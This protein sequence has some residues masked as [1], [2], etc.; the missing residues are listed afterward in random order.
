MI[1]SCCVLVNFGHFRID[2][3]SDLF[4]RFYIDITLNRIFYSKDDDPNALHGR[5]H[6]TPDQLYFRR[7]LTA[8]PIPVWL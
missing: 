1:T 2:V 5:A 7:A 6:F 4:C 8:A 3:P